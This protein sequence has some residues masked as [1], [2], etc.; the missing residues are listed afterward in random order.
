MDIGQSLNEAINMLLRR[1]PVWAPITILGIVGSVFYAFSLPR[2][3]ETTAVIQVGNSQLSQR[4]ASGAV[5]PS[6]GQ[7]LRKIEQRIMARDNLIEIIEGYGLFQEE[8]PLSLGDQ[9]LR[10]RLATRIEQITDPAQSWRPDA[11]PTALT[12]TVR[13][14]DPELAARI[15]NDFV[16]RVLEQNRAERMAQANRTL[17]F[18]ESEEKRVGAEISRL[19]ARIAEFKRQNADSLEAVLSTQQERLVALENSLLT[20]EQQIIELHNS[21]EKLRKE[22]FQQQLELA[23]DQQK[24]ILSRREDIQSALDAAPQVERE[25]NALQRKLDQLEDQFSIIST[26]RSEAEISQMLEIGRQSNQLTVLETALVPEHPVS[27]NRK[28]IVAVGGVLSLLVAGGI[29]LVLELL[30]P[31]IRTTAQMERQLKISPVVSIPIVKTRRDKF[32]QRTI[33]LIWFFVGGLGIWQFLQY[34][35][36]KAGS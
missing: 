28:K 16:E 18:F 34:L 3:Y 31:V 5:Q 7:Y 15:T 1:I 27:P 25:F 10:L 32:F 22:D 36:R 21:K 6:V 19:D 4:V 17:Q 11:A 13:L 9:V 35:S 33:I 14:S 24:L 23:Q 26:N 8:P 29:V 30:N 12:V 20:V 2:L